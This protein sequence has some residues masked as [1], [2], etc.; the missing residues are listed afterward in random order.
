MASRPDLNGDL[1]IPAWAVKTV[2]KAADA[3]FTEVA[4]KRSFKIVLPHDDELQLERQ[5]LLS[6]QLVLEDDYLGEGPDPVVRDG[7][8]ISCLYQYILDFLTR[9]IDSIVD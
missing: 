3:F 7:K 6:M 9:L 1:C 4:I 2:T 5:S 8:V